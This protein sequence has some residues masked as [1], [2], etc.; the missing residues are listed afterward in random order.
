MTNPANSVSDPSRAPVI[1]CPAGILQGSVVG[2]V[3][4]YCGIPYAHAP[5]GPLRFAPAKR[6]Q[7]WAGERDATGFGHAS[8]PPFDGSAADLE[9]FGGTE[10][11]VF[12]LATK[13]A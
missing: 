3:E 6:L 1:T 2:G 10:P 11:D 9:E 4:R 5:V 8:A 13:T 12:G 7:G